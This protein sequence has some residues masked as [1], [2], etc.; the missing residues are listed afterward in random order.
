[1]GL[2]LRSHIKA[3][4]ADQ[5]SVPAIPAPATPAPAMPAGE[6][7]ATKNTQTI[8]VEIPLLPPG[9]HPMKC[10]FCANP[11]NVF[12]NKD[13]TLA[14]SSEAPKPP[15]TSLRG[16]NLYPKRGAHPIVIRA[17]MDNRRR[18]DGTFKNTVAM[19]GTHGRTAVEMP[20]YEP[21]IKERWLL[22]DSA[23]IEYVKPH[24][25]EGRVDR[26]WQMHHRWR[27]TRRL[28][29]RS[30]DHWLWL[31]NNKIPRVV[32]QRKYA[33]VP[34]S[35]GFKIKE[36]TEMF[37]GDKLPRGAG[38]VQTYY[39]NTFSYMFAQ[40]AYEKVTGIMD[41][42]R[43]ELYGCELE[44]LET[45]YFRQRPGLEFWFG[46]CSQLGIQIYVPESCFML[47]AQDVV[48]TERGQVMAQYHGYMAYG[49]K[50]PSMEEARAR[51]E[52]LGMDPIEENLIGAW[53]GYYPW[54]I[55]AMNEGVAAMNDLHSDMEFTDT[56]KKLNVW[57]DTS[58]FSGASL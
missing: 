13:G 18:P 38:Y 22:N 54:H 10:P 16:S 21:G 36:I 20:W 5:Q 41:W 44:Q 8:A 47:F 53:D 46:V 43:I 15:P 29:R 50:S 37:I 40:V 3:K 2:A 6:L 23:S 30:A 33:D 12:I 9:M 27:F 57:I 45:E 34:N 35:E 58:G 4:H 31:Q 56:N 17:R 51:N 7:G 49:Y 19:M 26:W 48:G 52:A 42:E 14:S 32:M 39:T 25:E 55:F 11:T 28:T 24:V 1:M